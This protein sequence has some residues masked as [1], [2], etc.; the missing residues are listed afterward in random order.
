MIDLLVTVL[1]CGSEM[2][3]E[4]MSFCFMIGYVMATNC[5]MLMMVLVYFG[6]CF[7]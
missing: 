6:C 3:I 7:G 1:C 5:C 2:L 4:V